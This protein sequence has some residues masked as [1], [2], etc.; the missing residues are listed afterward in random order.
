[1]A[2]G[3]GREHFHHLERGE[4]S[5]PIS[6]PYRPPSPSEERSDEEGQSSTRI[7]VHEGAQAQGSE[8]RDPTSDVSSD[9]EKLPLMIFEPVVFFWLKQTTPPRSWCDQDG[10]QL[11][12]FN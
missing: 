6:T 4:V 2:E 12:S 5:V 3:E 10:L 1:M 8:V 7:P 11:I 9:E